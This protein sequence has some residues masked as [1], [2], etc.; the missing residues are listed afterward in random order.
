M[1]SLATNGSLTV[2]LMDIEDPGEYFL[3]CKEDLILHI[4]IGEVGPLLL[5]MLG[6]GDL[7]LTHRAW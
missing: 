1:K 7:S 2:V 5:E 3:S 6:L 4:M